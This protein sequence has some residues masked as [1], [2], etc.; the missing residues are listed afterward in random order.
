M[1][2]EKFTHKVSG[3]IWPKRGCIGR[4]GDVNHGENKCDMQIK[5]SFIIIVIMIDSLISDELL[6]L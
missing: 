1:L 3:L 5:S 4:G 6:E 2:V